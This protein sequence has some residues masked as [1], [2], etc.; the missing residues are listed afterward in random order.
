MPS[1]SS[2]SASEL[3]GDEST[4]QNRKNRCPLPQ[5]VEVV[6]VADA[7]GAQIG[8][9]WVVWASHKSQGALKEAK[10]LRFICEIS[11]GTAFEVKGLFDKFLDGLLW[12]LPFPR[13][14]FR[15]ELLPE[16]ALPR[17]GSLQEPQ[18]LRWT[19]ERNVGR[20][21]ASLLEAHCLARRGG[22]LRLAGLS[23][24]AEATRLFPQLF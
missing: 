6:L 21:Y 24:R 10:A 9:L 14:R 5:S 18:M 13:L 15:S 7:A 17:S 4:Q 16:P 8:G 23:A 12:L 22:V 2:S 11:H 1:C 20:A 19:S 3:Q